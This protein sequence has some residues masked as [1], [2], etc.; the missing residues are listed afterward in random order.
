MLR[1]I[2]IATLLSPAAFCQVFEVASVKIHSGSAGNINISTSGPRFR[3]S[4]ETVGGLVLYAYSLRIYQLGYAS[5]VILDDE[6]YDI[7]AKADGETAPKPD[8]FRRMLQSLLADRFK[9]KF[10]HE[11]RETPVYALVV[12][13]SGPK[14]KQSAPDAVSYGRHGVNGRYQ[15]MALT[16]ATMEDLAQNLWVYAGLPVVDKTGLAGTYEIRIE[17]T[18]FDRMSRE[19]DRAD[20]SVFQAIQQLGLK[21]EPQKTMIDVLVV[22]HVERPS[23][24]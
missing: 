7:D 6:F 22:D 8:E 4:A 18:P 24:N 14:L 12:G 17:A 3:A 11:L 23:G 20:I 2:S 9:L 19:L 13:K 1:A 5:K 10:H 16:N 15:T 21:L